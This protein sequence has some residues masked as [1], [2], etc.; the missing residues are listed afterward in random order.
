VSRVPKD[1]EAGLAAEFERDAENDELWE[2]VPSP[3][4]SS[5]RRTL[6]TQVTVRLDGRS[7][8]QL[9]EIARER[10]VGYTSLLRTWIEE[11]LNFEAA[12]VRVS[13]PQITRAG[14]TVI[15]EPL[16]QL[17]GAGRMV[18]TGAA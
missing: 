6:G 10:G 9:R 1:E 8:Q 5:P 4:P 18:G 12:S 17:S 11:R 15:E 7:A 2:E 13:R 16:V 3:P 14:F